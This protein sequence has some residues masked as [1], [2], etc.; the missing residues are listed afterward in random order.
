MQCLKVDAYPS[1]LS[2][3]QHSAVVR[4]KVSNAHLLGPTNMPSRWSDGV[5]YPP[6]AR[7]S[8]IAGRV[9]AT[10]RVPRVVI[11]SLGLIAKP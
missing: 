10:K 3:P 7:T 8:G 4:A 1:A 11:C 2:R 6:E 9:N 5:K